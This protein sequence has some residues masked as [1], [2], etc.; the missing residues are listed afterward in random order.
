MKYRNNNLVENFRR[1][2]CSFVNKNDE[3]IDAKCGEIDEDWNYLS[4][5]ILAE[6]ANANWGRKYY[7]KLTALKNIQVR[8]A[9]EYFDEYDNLF[10][11][12]G[13]V[14]K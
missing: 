11:N 3:G 4:D 14:N 10:L 5:R 2:L 1:D 9:L 12:K 7:Y 6:I 8:K 13:E